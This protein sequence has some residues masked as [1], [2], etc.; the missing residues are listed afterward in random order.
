MDALLEALNI[1]HRYLQL[2]ISELVVYYLWLALP[3]CQQLE[4]LGSDITA[5]PSAFL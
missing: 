5:Q 1:I 3:Y 4:L 2:E